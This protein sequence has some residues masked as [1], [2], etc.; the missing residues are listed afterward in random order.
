MD[1]AKIQKQLLDMQDMDYRDFHSR[2]MP[3]I[4]KDRIIG[5]RTPLLRSFAKKLDI[6]EC[7]EFLDT[8]PHYYYEENNLHA[9]LLEK[10]P[11]F[12]DALSETK[13][14][15]PYIDNWATC[16]SFLPKVFKKNTESLLSEI[17]NW[18]NAKEPFTVRYAA[19]LLMKLYLDENFSPEYPEL[20]SKIQSDEYYV[21][22]M[23]AWYFATALA[24]QYDNI[25]P[26][27]ENYRLDARV[28]NKTIQ[29]AVESYRIPAETKVYLKT[30]KV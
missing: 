20:L 21:N 28:H 22:M 23:L 9:F 13:R 24:K 27:I 4:E 1:T 16:D 6:N 14:F 12:T 18:L 3:T 19:G 25:L 10:I 8:L 29:K 26:Y 17:K 5:I 15:L 30:L 7:K 2:L 11:D